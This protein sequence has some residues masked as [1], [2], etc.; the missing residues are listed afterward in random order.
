MKG[1]I[2]LLLIAALLGAC[3]T[4]EDVA[5][6]FESG[7]AD[8]N[9]GGSG[10]GGDITTDDLVGTWVL[11]LDLER[12]TLDNGDL[13]GDD[14]SSSI[15]SSVQGT[16]TVVFALP[17]GFLSTLNAD[18]V[19][20]QEVVIASNRFTFRTNTTDIPLDAEPIDF[21]TVRLTETS[22]NT[23]V[24]VTVTIPGDGS[25][26]RIFDDANREG[27]FEFEDENERPEITSY[28]LEITDTTFITT[29]Q[30]E[31]STEDETFTQTYSIDADTN[32]INLEGEAID[33]RANLVGNDQLTL[34][35]G[36]GR[37]GEF[38]RQ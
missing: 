19:N 14:D 33:V 35:F 26:M 31:G 36:D 6:F 16:W 7:F 4:G 17:Q 10:S 27:R 13:N 25:E 18:I 30:R 2:A 24:N 8:D 15:D 12:N 23:F 28:V 29:I 9:G 22:S 37:V 38:D 21:D 32:D 3:E 11:D 1:W 5:D 34:T 20:A